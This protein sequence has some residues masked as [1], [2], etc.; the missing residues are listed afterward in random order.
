VLA[1]ASAALPVAGLQRQLGKEVAQ[2]LGGDRQKL[3]ITGNVHDRLGD[4]ERDDLRVGHAAP[5][6]L[7][8]FRQEIVGRGEDRGEQQVEI[9]EHR[10]PL[11][12]RRNY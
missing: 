2:A 7:S 5:G 1:A 4:R 11:G 3:A 8:A 10:G 12:R 6:V 9:G